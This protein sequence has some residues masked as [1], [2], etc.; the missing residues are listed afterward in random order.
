MRQKRQ[1]RY[2][3]AATLALAA[4]ALLALPAGAA[5]DDLDLI[6]R[7]TG[8]VGAPADGNSSFAHISA[9]GRWVTF[10]SEAANLSAEDKTGTNLFLRDTV[11]GTTTYVNRADGPA[12]APFLGEAF[13]TSLSGDGRR[14]V[15][16]GR[17]E[18]TDYSRVYLR[19]VS[20]ATTTLVSRATG[21]AGAPSDVSAFQPAISADGRVV[22]YES[23]ATNLS[24][25]DDHGFQA[26][27]V[28]VR[29]LASSTTTLVSRAGGPGGAGGNQPSGSPSVSGDGRFVAFRS[30]ATNLS[31]DDTNGVQDV[32]VRDRARDLTILVSRASGAAGA[33]GDDFAAQATLSADG[34]YV[35]FTSAANNLSDDDDDTVTNVYVRDLVANTTTLVSRANGVAGAR[36]DGDSGGGSLSADGRFAAF[37][38]QADNLSSE[39]DNAVR[40]VFVRDLVAGTTTLVSRSA[41]AAGAAGD[42]ESL[43]PAISADGRRVAFESDGDN[44]AAD[45]LNAVRNVF[46]R[47]LPPPVAAPGAPA[48]PAAPAGPAGLAPIRAGGGGAPARVVRCAGVR[49]T[50]VGTNG[51]NVIRGTAKRDVIAALGGN[52]VVSGLGGDDLI[53]LGA[54]N[55]TGI[56]GAGADRI[57]GEAGADRAEGGP[58][59]DLLE[60]GPGRDLLLGGAGIDRLLG[61]AGKDRAVGGLGKD[62]CR[63]ESGQTC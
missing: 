40:N 48:A 10:R 3:A 56:G 43:Y 25:D 21:A 13:V 20:A 59:R 23:T 12:G 24:P 49:A 57:L 62:I 34:R 31:Q 58:G 2:A 60:G 11:T 15:F 47:T 61:A 14:V 52:D 30:D 22:A 63:V 42:G 51:R 32:Y 53:C 8:P 26:T 1:I 36:A 17:L 27:D 39:D 5:D 6:S 18:A 28:F 33:V 7:A 46:V 41:G 9:D 54:G 44:L 45:D 19:D 16:D 35:L 4:A 55:D 50:I 37:Y 38:S 29:D